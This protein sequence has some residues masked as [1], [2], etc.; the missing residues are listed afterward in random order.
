MSQP[1][2]RGN[3]KKHHC[4]HYQHDNH[5]SRTN[6]LAPSSVLKPD[7]CASCRSN[8]SLNYLP[9]ETDSHST[10]TTLASASLIN[11]LVG[12]STAPLAV[13]SVIESSKASES[14]PLPKIESNAPKSS[15]PTTNRSNASS[16]Y[17]PCNPASNVVPGHIQI[18]ASLEKSDLRKSISTCSLP[19]KAACSSSPQRPDD[20]SFVKSDA[21]SNN[22]KSSLL[23]KTVPYSSPLKQWVVK[24]KA[25]KSYLA[26]KPI[27]VVSPTPEAASSPICSTKEIIISNFVPSVA[28]S[29]ASETSLPSEVE[30]ISPRSSHP[31]K[32]LSESSDSSLLCNPTP[33]IVPGCMQNKPPFGQSDVKLNISTSSFPSKDLSS[34]SPQSVD[35]VSFVQSDVKSNISTS[36][37]AA[38]TISSSIPLKQHVVPLPKK[39][40]TLAPSMQW[41]V[42][43]STYNGSPPS[44]PT[45]AMSF[46]PKAAS[47]ISSTKETITSTL[48]KAGPE[49]SKFGDAKLNASTKSSSSKAGP[50]PN[51]IKNP[52]KV[53]KGDTRRYGIPKRINKMLKNG[54]VPS[55]LEMQ[56]SPKTYADYL[57]ALLYAEDIYCEVSLL[58]LV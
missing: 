9:T 15:H 48:P 44:N 26:S 21:K 49:Q 3:R 17:L 36:S 40:V 58:S 41:V 47:P 31:S 11:N 20:V 10:P 42:K 24:S 35:T 16:S 23:T 46:T 34:S 33:K 30:S 52:E 53:G 28:K 55:V 25:S 14:C 12:K 4:Y 38:E 18:K 56:L 54:I 51:E 32:I 13:E 29:N 6:L 19:S 7:S 50:G 1:N 45:T 8:A 27:P 39:S 43:S 5:S 37:L 2:R 22:P 57:A